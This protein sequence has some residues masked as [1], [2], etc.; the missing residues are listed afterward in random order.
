MRPADRRPVYVAEPGDRR[1]STTTRRISRTPRRSPPATAT[2][3]G[4]SAYGNRN[5]YNYFTDWFGSTRTAAL[6]LAKSESS[7]TV[8]VVSQGSRWALADVF[9]WNELNR[10]FGPTLTVSDAFIG[11]LADRGLGS[12]IVRDPSTGQWAWSPEAASGI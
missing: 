4:C 8:W 6:T 9:E 12:N 1:T 5:F 2:G 3:D 10:V 7:P 11:S